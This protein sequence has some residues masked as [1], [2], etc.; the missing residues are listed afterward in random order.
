MRFSIV[1][2][3]VAAF[4]IAGCGGS[5]SASSAHT[6]TPATLAVNHAHS[7]LVM[8]SNADDV[9]MGAHYRLYKSTNGGKS[10]HPLVNQ[11]VLSMVLDPA[12]P[13]TIYAVSL[14]KGLEKSIDGGVHWTPLGVGISKGHLTGVAFVPTSHVVLAYG[15]GIY[16]SATGGAQWSSVLAKQSIYSIA[17]GADGTAYAASSN[18][19]YVSHDAGLH[20]KIVSS[21][22]NQPVVQAAAS[23]NVAYAIAAV[24]LMKSTDDGRTWKPLANAPAV[25]FIGVSPTN[26]NE[27]F[28]EIGAQGFVMSRDGGITWR[29]ADQGITD[30]NFNAS[31]VRI[32]PSSPNVVYTAAWGLHFYA[33]K[34]GGQHWT[35][36][37]TLI[38]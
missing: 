18:G 29:K 7:I 8:P 14:Q 4:A 2:I 6:S 35:R 1:L 31:V 21:I 32:S 30:R 23:G 9:L 28:G 37:S 17:V 10:W 3:L 33:S 20:W 24:A 13:S 22:G 11:M 16:R 15:V 27:V 38:H 5:S 19:L 12:R 34:D 25:E 26:P 36:K